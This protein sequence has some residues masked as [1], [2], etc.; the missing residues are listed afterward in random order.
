MNIAI[1]EAE[2]LYANIF[3]TASDGVLIIDLEAGNV[4]AANPAAA[5]MHGYAREA[6]L[7]LQLQRLIQAKSLPL[8]ADYAQVIRQGGLFAT[9]AQHVQRDDTLFSV[10]WRAVAFKYQGRT[11][12]LALLRDVSKRT[13]AE[14][15]LRRRVGVRTHE[16]SA[17]LEISQ[18]LASTLELQPARILDQLGVLIPYTHAGLFTLEDSTL[19]ALAV[20]SSP[21]SSMG[22]SSPGSS[23]GRSSPG[24]STGRSSPGSSMGRS[25]PG[26]STGSGAE[27]LEKSVPFRIRMNGKETLAALFN[28]H[29]PIRIADVGGNEPSAKFLRT[30]LVNDSAAL[31]EGVQSWIWVPLA[32]KDHMIGAIGIAHAERD[33]FTPHQADLALA[34][35][36]QVAITMV[37][38]ELYEHARALAALQER[39]RLAQNLHD[40]VNQSLFS[41]GLIAEVL[42]RLWE[43][44]PDDARHSLEDLRRLI[45][46]ALA[47]M[48]ALLAELQP[49]VL[50]DSSL[51][52]LLRQLANAFTGRSN[53]PAS[54][55]IVGDYVLSAEIQVAVY[56]ICQEALNNIAKHAGASRVKIDLC[57]AP[58]SLELHIRDNGCGYVTS[59]LTPA[60]HYGLGM[61]RERAEAVGAVLT[62][63]GR[64]GHGTEITLRW[65][66]APKQEA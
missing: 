34:I 39:Q 17:L 13:Q 51:G 16:Q 11:C 26:S 63:A 49:S 54:V 21:G 35:A 1:S 61:M 28:E 5:A 58:G 38:A 48:R 60:G 57:Y 9:L 46:G 53:V 8:F 32:V 33:Y 50:T 30:L 40:A 56:R 6:F 15:W 43:R 27:R 22:R 31:L 14:L 10:E 41:A 55:N 19:V 52:D 29:L 65:Q 20:R 45:R 42:P 7:G 18:T 66:G 3:E 37:N 2:Q 64:P 44:D 36:D 23:M 12:A 4:L 47:E 59:E 62:V 24:S 25:S